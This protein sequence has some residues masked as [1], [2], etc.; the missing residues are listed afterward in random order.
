MSTAV[1]GS[2]GLALSGSGN[3]VAFA[4]SS[5][6]NTAATG[7]GFKN[8]LI[9]GAMAID[10][11][12][13]GASVSVGQTITYTVDRWAVYTSS[14]TG[15]VQRVSGS[16]AYQ[17]ALRLTGV[18]TNTQSQVIQ[19]IESLNCYDLANSSAT[20]SVTLSSSTLTAVG[21]AVSY[22][23]SGVADDWSSGATTISSGTF[24]IT[25][26]PAQYTATIS[27]LGA[28]AIKGLQVWFFT[29][30]FTS[31]TLDIT[32]VQFEKSP[33]ATSFDYRPYGTEFLLCQ[34][35]YQF[36]DIWANYIFIYGATIPANYGVKSTIFFTPMRTGVSVV[37]YNEAGTA[38]RFSIN[39]GG[40]YTAGYITNN[41]GFTMT[42]GTGGGI[43]GN[44]V[45]FSWRASAEL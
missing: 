41:E 24:N 17:Y 28:N 37:A 16:G 19:R 26:T 20:L 45:T 18:A 33:T 12:N 35:Y 1:S 8:R 15:A 30:S 11:R 13:G 25:S 23:T 5:V 22:P 21:W 10:Q 2:T 38:N 7:F 43:S 34:R 4:D 32:G 40:A 44:E 29:G 6:Q 39:R 14:G 27:S 36:A 31:G 9:N 42:N 3:Q